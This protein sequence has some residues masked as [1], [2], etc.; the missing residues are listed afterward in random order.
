MVYE[1]SEKVKAYLRAGTRMVLVVD[2]VLEA[3]TVYQQ[4][5]S[6]IIYDINGVFD[7]ETVLPGFKLPIHD[8]FPE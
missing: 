4:N 3:I 8:I 5:K 1:V 7:G 6:P 2:P